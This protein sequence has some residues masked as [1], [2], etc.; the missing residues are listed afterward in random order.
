MTI[1]STILPSNYGGVPVFPAP[2]PPGPYTLG[3]PPSN[4]LINGSWSLYV[5]DTTGQ[6]RGVIAGG[7][8]LNYSTDINVQG[9]EEDVAIPGVG[10]GPGNASIYP[11]VFNLESVPAGVPVTFVD[12]RLTMSHTFPDNLRILLESPSGTV[13]V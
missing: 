13:V 4:T 1:S 8:S 7:W 3:L 2:A 10:T 11:I 12:L 9:H 5:M 6:N